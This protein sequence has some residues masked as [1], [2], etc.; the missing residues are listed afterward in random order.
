[1][2][3]VWHGNIYNSCV[4]VHR[5]G[6]HEKRLA[7]MGLRINWQYSMLPRTHVVAMNFS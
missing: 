3:Q 2:L 7:H 4:L 1:M 5:H 6:V